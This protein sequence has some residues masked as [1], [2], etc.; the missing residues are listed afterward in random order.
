MRCTFSLPCSLI[1]LAT[2][3][4]LPFGAAAQ[5]PHVGVKAGV[6]LSNLYSTEAND[7]HM[8]IGFNAGLM[9]RTM[10]DQPFG[11]QA[12]LLYTT[13]GNKTHY[14]GFFGLVDQDVTF[15]LNYLELPVLAC[16]RLADNAVELQV[17]GYAGY[18]L[19]SQVTSEG[20]LGNGSDT[21]DTD[22]LN[23]MDAGLVGGVAFNAGPAQIG[24]RYEYGLARIANS[25]EA[26]LLLGDAKNSCAQVYVAFGIPGK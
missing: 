21:I 7:D 6:N 12:E 8:L 25:D 3:V 4:L 9:G 22:K 17:G 18:L 16:F 20:D 26:D 23:Q 2:T 10:L 24:V 1:M 5:G 19:S 14:Q 13:K 11:L 15:K